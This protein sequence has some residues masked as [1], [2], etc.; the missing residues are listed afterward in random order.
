MLMDALE[1]AHLFYF[2]QEVFIN[3]HVELKEKTI[4]NIIFDGEKNCLKIKYAAIFFFF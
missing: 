2:V 4:V 1:H 3:L